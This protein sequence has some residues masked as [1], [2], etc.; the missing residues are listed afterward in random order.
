MWC[1]YA[2]TSTKLAYDYNG[3]IFLTNL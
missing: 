3:L 2:L 1:K